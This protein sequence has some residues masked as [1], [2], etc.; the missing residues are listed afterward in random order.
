VYIYAGT[1]ANQRLEI[2]TS[3]GATASMSNPSPAQRQLVTKHINWATVE[4]RLQRFSQIRH[5]FPIDILKS[6]SEDPPYYCHYMAWRLGTWKNEKCFERLD[7]LLGTACALPNWSAQSPLLKSADFAE[8]WSL[9]WQ[10]QMAEYLYKIGSNVQWLPSGPDLSVDVDEEWWFVEC[11]AYRKSFGLMSLLEEVLRQIDPSIRIDRDLCLPFNLPNNNERSEFLHKV[12]SLFLDAQYI[13]DARSKSAYAYPVVMYQ[14]KDLT[15][16]YEG[17]NA[18]AYIPGVVSTQ[19]GCQDEY[20]RVALSEA[21]KAK[22]CANLLGTHH[23]NLVVANFA[24]SEDFQMAINPSNGLGLALTKVVLGP[25]IDA[26]A[27]SAVGIDESIEHGK[28]RLVK[29]VS[30]VSERLNLIVSSS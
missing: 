11:Y 6:K 17:S 23:P 29:A 12:L 3:G 14:D 24:L 4:R 19:V 28:I 15:V 10:L 8:F 22:M 9:I 1:L 16:Y 21:V 20:L 27:I 13:A 30:S 7:E 2:N 26:F 25:N 18:N 5:A